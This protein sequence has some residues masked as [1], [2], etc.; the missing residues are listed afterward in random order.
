MKDI[1]NKWQFWIVIILVVIVIVLII[2]K[3]RKVDGSEGGLLYGPSHKQGGI[4]TIIKSTGEIVELQGG[5]Y[6]LPTDEMNIQEKY[7]CE[8]TPR[9]IANAINNLRNGINFPDNGRCIIKNK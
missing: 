9:E 3:N 5:E 7:T 1:Y 8:G 6:I 2:K 4:K